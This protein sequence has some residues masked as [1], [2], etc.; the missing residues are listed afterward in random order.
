VLAAL[1]QFVP[2]S[3]ILFGSD[4]PMV[5]EMAVK[6]ET[7]GLET[8]KVLDDSTRNAIDR[9][10]ALALFPRFGRTT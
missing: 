2:P 1:Q 7:S 6:L 5:P 9:Q 8:S 4:F 10:N 3:Q